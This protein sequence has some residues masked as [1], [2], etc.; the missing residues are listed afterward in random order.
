MGRV[1]PSLASL[2]LALAEVM[3]WLNYIGD[4]T[5]GAA[6]LSEPL[7]NVFD[8]SDI[9]PGVILTKQ[10]SRS[11]DGIGWIIIKAVILLNV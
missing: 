7:A 9:K 10:A 5:L 1:F 6:E 4:V 2:L 3:L 8:V 11:M